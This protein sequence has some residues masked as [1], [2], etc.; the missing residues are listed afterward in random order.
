MFF[1]LVCSAKYEELMI[2]IIDDKNVSLFTII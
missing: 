1:F 2:W